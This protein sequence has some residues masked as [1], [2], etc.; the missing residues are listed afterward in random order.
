MSLL[1]PVEHSE[2]VMRILLALYNVSSLMEQFQETF[3]A[4]IQAGEDTAA[5]REETG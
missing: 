2:Y 1:L 5:T 4:G 3:L